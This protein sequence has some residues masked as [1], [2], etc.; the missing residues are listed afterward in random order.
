MKIALYNP[1]WPVMGGGERYF[2][3]IAEVLSAE[4]R[5]DLIVSRP[6]DFSQLEDR[7][8]VS[9]SKVGRLILRGEAVAEPATPVQWLR[10]R[11]AV[12]R[13]RRELRQVTSGYDLAFALESDQPFPLS[14]RRNILHIQVPHRRW[15]TGDFLEAISRRQGRDARRALARW[16]TF[17]RALRSFDFILYNSQ[18]TARIVEESWSPGLPHAVLYPPID[19]PA[20]VPRWEDKRNLVLAVGRFFVGG[21]EKRHA[22]IVRAFRQ[23][24]RRTTARWELHLVGGAGDDATAARLIAELEEAA[25]D[26]PVAFHLNAPRTELVRLYEAAKMLWHATGFGVDETKDPERVEHFGIV[27]AEAMAY[28]AIPLVVNR[29][30]LREIVEH[31]TNGFVWETVEQL[32]EQAGHLAEAES[33]PAVSLAAHERSRFFSRERF[34]RALGDI[35]RS[36]RFD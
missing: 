21:H 17:R 31:G 23:F 8:G 14:A 5:V 1:G 12:E 32:V 2:A 16:L 30:G 26:L 6:V 10:N 35:I 4:H 34:A 27:V 18:F 11:S 13:L 33:A 29:G 7:L 3:T 9:L 25:R 19:L 36:L 15:K 20:K 28:G 24:S 22:V